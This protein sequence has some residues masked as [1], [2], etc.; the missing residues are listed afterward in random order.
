MTIRCALKP[1]INATKGV[2]I[3]YRAPGVEAYQ[4]LGM[5]K[6]AKGWYIVTVPSSVMKAGS[7]QVYFDAR[8]TADNELASNGQ[9]DSPSAIEIRKKGSG[10]SG[11]GGGDEDPMKGIKDKDK[12][13][14]YEAG[15]H[16]R[17]EGAYWFGMGGGVG[18][19]FVPAGNLEWRK[20]IKV[21]A[22][23]APVGAYHLVPEVGYLYSEGFAVALQG[24]VEIIQ[25]QQLQ[26]ECFGSKYSK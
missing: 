12:A 6:T 7:L 14:R 11:G 24:I 26:G 16:R 19:G 15:L 4:A 2:Q 22:V 5:R 8:D 10:R 3:H 18:W 17:R 9:V 25:Q 23:T 20:S 21:S 1:G 13:D